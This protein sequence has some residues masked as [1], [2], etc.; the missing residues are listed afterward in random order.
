[1]LV[2]PVREIKSKR[3]K[4]GKAKNMLSLFTNGINIYANY[5]KKYNNLILQE[6][7]MCCCCWVTKSCL[8]LCH[9]MNCSTPGFPVLHYLLSLL[10]LMSIESV[11]SSSHIILCCPL[12]LPSIFPSIRVSFNESALCNQWPKYWNF[13]FTTS[14]FKEHLGFISFRIDWFDLLAVQGILE[15]PAPQDMRSILKNDCTARY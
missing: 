12:L 6:C 4:G 1:M 13:S 3:H 14:P 8:T 7:K 15:S 2:A 9:Y 5:T 10:K 11:M